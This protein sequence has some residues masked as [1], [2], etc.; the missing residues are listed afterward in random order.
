MPA[1]IQSDLL[2]R[3]R[4]WLIA[5]CVCGLFLALSILLGLGA[6]VWRMQETMELVDD[7]AVSDA[8]YLQMIERA[9]LWSKLGLAIGTVAFAG[10]L[11]SFVMHQRTKE[12][13]KSW[14]EQQRLARREER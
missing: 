8:A 5:L 10:Y 1:E 12:K 7:S 2:Q 11:V 6:T 3:K 4:R 9:T 13:L 14:H